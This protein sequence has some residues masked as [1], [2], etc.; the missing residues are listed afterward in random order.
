MNKHRPINRHIN[1]QQQLQ[2]TIKN[3]HKKQYK[4]IEVVVL[5]GE[6]PMA[7][8]NKKLGSFKLVGIPPAP[9]G[10][11]KFEVTFHTRND[12]NNNNNNNNNNK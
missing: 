4:R 10:I 6:R 5:Q 11:P 3:A 2:H 9:A 7:E 8:D 12:N 1:I